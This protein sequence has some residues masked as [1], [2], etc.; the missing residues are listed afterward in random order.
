MDFDVIIIG[1]GPAGLTASIYCV[2]R[3]LKTLVVERL[4][5]GGQMLL[6]NEIGNWP[7]DKMVSGAVLASRMEDHA[8]SLG[9]EFA[10]DEVKGL[11]LDGDEKQVILRD[12]QYSAKAVILATGGMHKRLK[13]PGEQEYTGKGVSYCATCDGPFFKDKQVAVIGGGNMALEDALYLNE[14]ADKTYL[15]MSKMSAEEILYEKVKDSGVEVIA[16][17]LA[18]VEGSSLVEA[19][20]LKSGRHLAVEG[21]FIA[22]GS[23]PSTELAQESGIELDERGFVK[24]DRSCKTNIEGVYAA[25]DV[26]GGI[27]QISTAVG[28]GATAALTAYGYVKA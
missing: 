22:V 24:I 27:P 9:V 16:D 11:E 17:D 15:V 14:V 10:F 2:R 26:T 5:T 4:A 12:K 25:G 19:A 1:G 7:G 3:K 20:L 8:K 28:E 21:V 13:V 6:T 18:A 23:K